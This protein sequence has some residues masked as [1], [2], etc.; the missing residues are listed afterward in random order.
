MGHAFS[1]CRDSSGSVGR[2]Y[3]VRRR[4][5]LGNSRVTYFI[6]DKGIIQDSY[7]KE[8]TT[9]SHAR[10]ALKRLETLQ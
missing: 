2:L 7:H 5:G 1:L 6:D 4:F 9:S 10:R 8:L 3:D